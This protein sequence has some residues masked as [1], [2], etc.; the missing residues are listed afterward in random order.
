MHITISAIEADRS[1]RRSEAWR[2]LPRGARRS[3]CLLTVADLAAVE[4]AY[5]GEALLALS[6]MDGDGLIASGLIQRTLRELPNLRAVIGRI[7]PDV[8]EAE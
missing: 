7:D 2:P 6:R 3:D 5:Y 1:V 4:L 8:V